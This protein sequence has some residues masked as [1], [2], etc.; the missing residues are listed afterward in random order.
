MRA[1][2]RQRRDDML[3]DV[4]G[5]GFPSGRMAG[6]ATGFAWSAR[7]GVDAFAAERGGWGWGKVLGLDL[8][9]A[10]CERVELQAQSG[11]FVEEQIGFGAQLLVEEDLGAQLFV[12][13]G[14]VADEGAERIGI[15][16]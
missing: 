5:D 9:Q 7:M 12:E 15:R 4:I 11:V 13:K 6:L 14:V 2:R 10:L 3:V 1:A 8:A 16:A